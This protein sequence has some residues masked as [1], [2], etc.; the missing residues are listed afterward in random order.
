MTIPPTKHHLLA[1]KTLQKYSGTNN[2]YDGTSCINNKTGTNHL[3]GANKDQTSGIQD[4]RHLD[5]E[6]LARIR[7]I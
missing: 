1:T 3:P 6:N 4:Q 2:H 5:M 7:M